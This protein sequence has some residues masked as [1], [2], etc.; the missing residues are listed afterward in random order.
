MKRIIRIL[1][2]AVALVTGLATVSAQTVQVLVTP[3]TPTLPT[4]VTSYLDDPLRYFN[5]QFYVN[6]AGSEG[7]DVFIDLQLTL[8]TKP[9][10]IQT[11]P[12]SIPLQPLHLTEGPNILRRDELAPQIGSRMETNIVYN[13]PMDMQQ[14]PE[15]TYQFCVDVH[16][17]SDH[18]D[19]N[20]ESLTLGPCSSFEICYSGSAPELVSPLAGT[21]MDLNGNMIVIPA[22]RI[23]FF[24]PKSG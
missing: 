15:G 10:Y 24:W 5:I 19:P 22:K 14:L 2:L 3:K 20:P 13:N 21:Q 1:V 12:G 11:K 16:R 8:D 23:N 9:Y 6:G 17:W 7:L 18:N 4:T